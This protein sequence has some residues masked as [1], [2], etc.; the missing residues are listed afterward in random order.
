MRKPLLLFIF[1]MGACG[2][3]LP[4]AMLLKR[5]TPLHELPA[6]LW[7]N[8]SAIL[9]SSQLALATATSILLLSLLVSF[10]LPKKMA[11]PI[12]LLSLLPYLFTG[13]VWAIALIG[14]WNHPGLPGHIYDSPMILILALTAR[15]L[16]VGLIGLLLIN[17]F[18][19]RTLEEAALLS[20]AT[21][22]QTFTRITLPLIAPQLFLLWATIFI[23]AWGDL[24]SIVLLAPPGWAP[25]PLRLFTLMHYGPSRDVASLSLFS[26]VFCILWVL[27][28]FAVIKRMTRHRINPPPAPRHLRPRLP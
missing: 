2:T 16:W 27:I 5:A 25:L 17:V 3:L 8:T 15:Y 13:P 14:L 21:A 24:D 10:L 1:I 12:A 6:S 7:I 23:L 28:T 19:P 9:Q 20:G 22:W 11:A 18:R 4:L 26:M